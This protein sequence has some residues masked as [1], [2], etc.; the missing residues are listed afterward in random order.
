MA[1]Q[2]ELDELFGE[3]GARPR[4]RTGLVVTLLA[5]GLLATVLGMVCTAVP[6]GLLVL[7][8]WQLVEKDAD[9]VESGYL[10]AEARTTVVWLRRA[11]L[12]AIVLVVLLFVAQAVL[13]AMGFYDVLWAGFLE[14]AIDAWGP[15]QAAPPPP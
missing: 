13:L 6:G 12:A 7:V 8:A 11:T 5:V 3:A 4:P 1:H 15:P 10:P 9:R 14:R 2:D